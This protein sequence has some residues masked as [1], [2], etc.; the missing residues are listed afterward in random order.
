MIMFSDYW[1]DG[2]VKEKAVV[3]W[4]EVLLDFEFAVNFINFEVVVTFPDYIYHKSRSY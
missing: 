3:R 1:T 4:L 2:N